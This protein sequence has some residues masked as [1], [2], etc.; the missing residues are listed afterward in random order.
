ML[1]QNGD[2]INEMHKQAKGAS[3]DPGLAA[4]KAIESLAGKLADSLA[5]SLLDSFARA[6]GSDAY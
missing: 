3:Q 4:D 5:E 6:A 2:I 1:E